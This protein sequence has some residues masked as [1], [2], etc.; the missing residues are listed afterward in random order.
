[1]SPLP[2][3]GRGRFREMASQFAMASYEPELTL[4]GLMA[5]VDNIHPDVYL[6]EKFVSIA[7]GH[8][9]NLIEQ[10]GN[11]QQLARVHD[12]NPFGGSPYGRAHVKDDALHL[13]PIDYPAEFKQAIGGLQLAAL[14][15]ARD[16]GDI[17][18]D[19]LLRVALLKFLRTELHQQFN[20]VLELCREKLKQRDDHNLERQQMV[21][22]D[23]FLKFQ[24]NK[25]QVLRRV[26]DDLLS[27]MA[28]V[29]R[30]AVVSTRQS[31]FGT[32]EAAG[33]E[34]LTNRLIF[35]DSIS[36]PFLRAEH[37]ALFGSFDRDPD[38]FERMVTLAKSFYQELGLATSDG[39][40]EALLRV[41]ENAKSLMFSGLADETPRGR[42]QRSITSAWVTA[43][44]DANVMD[45]VVAAYEVVPILPDY[46]QAVSPQQL[47]CALLQKTEQ[48]RVEEILESLDRRP[49]DKLHQAAQR[50]RAAG[51]SER[52]RYAARYLI[53]ISRFYRDVCKVRVLETALESINLL[54]NARLRE[55]SEING[56]L[57]EYRLPEEEKPAGLRVNDHVV[58]KADVRDSSLL[59]RSMLERGLNP[60][61]FFS[62]NFFE[63]V[64]KLLPRYGAEKVFIEG[65]AIILAMLENEG[66][67]GFA[68]A[69]TCVMAQEML[70]I[71]SAY[72]KAS[73]ESGLPPL[74]IGIGIAY[75]ASSPVYLMDGAN[76]IMISA[77]LNLSDRLSAC[78]KRARREM[79]DTRSFFNVFVFQLADEESVA[80]AIEDFLLNYNVGGIHLPR[81]AFE[82]LRDEI[83]LDEFD[84][85]L[86]MP[87]GS[88]HVHFYRGLVPV[89]PG[90]FHPI[91]IREGRAAQ[92]EVREFN[93][94]RWADHVYYEVCTNPDL[95]E[96]MESSYPARSASALD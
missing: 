28:D 5:G 70:N 36:D 73:T 22:R 60:A 9:K 79:R 85:E 51:N 31:L 25:R 62:L 80:G 14:R 59:T 93:F 95:L 92:V 74:E 16:V 1:M 65:D 89:S 57:Y 19:L 58:L 43:L 3:F 54:N 24:V 6:S 61:S 11:V 38:L 77:A 45:Y 66:Q 82:K 27:T 86:T 48:K 63:P 29:E 52:M 91:L 69:R 40:A 84:A 44:E 71:V 15:R 20:L 68:V 13:E 90:V 41:P 37:Y 53:D 72:N 21:A 2:F 26:A 94:I 34:V 30:E 18:L 32:R 96:R 64:N 12:T 7:R 76:R 49:V 47:K 87:W 35:P 55:L 39:Q 88:D 75:Q 10:I 83:S 8:L 56:T 4:Q 23:R 67:H 46:G 78:H 17:N 50:V 81:A 42:A 33:Y